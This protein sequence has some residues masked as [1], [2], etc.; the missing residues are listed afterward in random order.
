MSK[1][2]E[3]IL[4]YCPDGV[5]RVLVGSLIDLYTGVQLNKSEMHEIGSFPVINGGVNPSGY[6]EQFNEEADTITVSQGG[7]S[8][9]Y[10]N[11]ITSN[12]WAGAHCFVVKP[13]E[14]KVNK[15]YLYN[16]LKNEEY[17][18][19]HTQQGAGIPS[20]NRDTINSLLI[21]LPP[22]PVQEEIVRILDSMVDLQNNIEAELKERKK[23]FEIYR[24][25]LLEN[26]AILSSEKYSCFKCLDIAQYIRG[27]TYNKEQES[28]KSLDSIPV[29][30]ANN[31]TLQTNRINFDEVKYIK[32]DARVKPEQYLKQNDIFICAGSG[33]KEHVGKVAFVEK[34]LNYCFGGFMAV[35]RAKERILPRYLYYHFLGNRF[36]DYLKKSLNSTTINNLNSSVINGFTI[37]LPSLPVQEEIVRILDSM[38]ALQDNLEAE[39]IERRK[40]YE[41]YRNKILSF[42]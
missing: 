21:P 37:P 20:V 14:R 6:I 26:G 33:S 16:F 4:K 24:S 27:V 32:K 23:Q 15:R 39:L 28:I 19:Q 2:E 8:A 10:V 18:L 36:N 1:L 7:A 35:I 12:F 9:G 40:Q 11:Y 38:T 31:I 13:S 30:R 5:E 41:Y 34:D 29:L 42:E 22:L 17:A 3:L 25:R